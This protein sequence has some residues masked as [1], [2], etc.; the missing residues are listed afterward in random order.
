M[1][2]CSNLDATVAVLDFNLLWKSLVGGAQS[3]CVKRGM[4]CNGNQQQNVS[5][6]KTYHLSHAHQD[7][8]CWWQVTA[9]LHITPNGKCMMHLWL[10]CF[11]WHRNTSSCIQ[12]GRENPPKHEECDESWNTGTVPAT[13]SPGTFMNSSGAWCITWVTDFAWV[14]V[15]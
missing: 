3:G 15:D 8:W 6:R 7:Y 10:C 13:L 1:V 4:L 12:A 14:Y 5:L 11:H 2:V 9:R